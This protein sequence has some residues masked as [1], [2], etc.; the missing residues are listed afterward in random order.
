VVRL[1]RRLLA[2]VLLI[3]QPLN[4]A[5]AASSALPMMAFRGPLAAIE[6]LVHGL[7]AAL[8][9]AAGSALWHSRPHG[10]GLATLALGGIAASSVQSLYWSTLPSQTQPGTEFPLAAFAVVHSAL[11]IAFLYATSHVA[12]SSDHEHK[13]SNHLT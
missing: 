12:P 13:L 7:I 9:V 4:F 3:W 10:P 11:W 5:A 1:L 2:A 8:S 6:L